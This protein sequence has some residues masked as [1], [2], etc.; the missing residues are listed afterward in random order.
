[1]KWNEFLNKV[2]VFL[3]WFGIG[4]LLLILE[5]FILG[6][7]VMSA[8]SYLP[9]GWQVTSEIFVAVVAIALSL[10]WS[11]LPN[12]RVKFA[13]LSSGI[14]SLINLILMILLGVVMFMF[15]CLNWVVVPGVECSIEGGKALA[16]LIFVAATGNYLTYGYTSPPADVEEA[17]E[18]REAVG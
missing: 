8:N 11:F 14:K 6:M 2:L 16:V 1:M 5:V 4:L 10:T 7:L 12:I 9:E 3:K 15:S 18:S 17:K 13:A